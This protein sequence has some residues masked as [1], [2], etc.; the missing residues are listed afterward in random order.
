MGSLASFPTEASE[1]QTEWVSGR[2]STLPAGTVTFLLTDVEGSSRLWETRPDDMPAAIARHYEILDEVIAAYDGVRPVEQGEGDSIVAAFARAG[3]AVQAAVEAQRQLTSELPWLPVRMAIHTGE[4]Q[5]RG[6]RNYVGSAIIRCARL[7]ACAHGGQVLLSSSTAG[8]VLDSPAG[9]GLVDLGAV[10]LRDLTR[11]ERV[12]QV[13]AD[14]LPA[15]FPPLRSLDAAPHNLPSAVTSF[16]GRDQELRTITALLHE[17]RVVTLTGSGGCGKTRLA[18]HAAAEVVDVHAGGTWWVDLAPV[19]NGANVPDQ[20]A[21]AVGTQPTPG[22]DTTALLVRY[23]RDL[24]PT[25]LILDNAEHVI[26]DVAAV[27][28]AIVQGCAEVHVLVTSRE[29]LGVAGELVWRV[30]SLRAPAS[31]ELISSEA[32]EGFEAARLFVDRARRVR[33]NLVLDDRATAAIVAICARLDGIPLA[34]ELAAARTRT[35]SLDRLASGLDNAFRLLTGGVRTAMP[36]QQTL[37][38]SIAWSVDLLDDVERAVLRRLAVF[39]GRSRWRRP[40]RSPPTGSS[41][42]RTSCST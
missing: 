6:E 27:V 25:L 37:L 31:G 1:G 19:T 15:Q 36:R 32:L 16:V 8:L 35:V 21:G 14:G 30:P 18:L 17:E 40:R 12:W 10:R 20:V 7:R 11:V 23:L 2:P 3:E 41:S 4:A 42:T 29:P 5:L 39:Q 38:A 13:V 24:G 33:P 28:D 9:V 34:L 22:A 26:D